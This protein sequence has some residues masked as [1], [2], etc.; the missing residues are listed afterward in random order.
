MN[1]H[2]IIQLRNN[3]WN[4]SGNN[5]IKSIFNILLSTINTFHHLKNNLFSIVY[6]KF[7]SNP[8]YYNFS[9]SV[10]SKYRTHLQKVYLF[11]NQNNNSKYFKDHILILFD[12]YYLLVNIIQ[13]NLY[14]VLLNIM[15][16]FYMEIH[17]L[18][19]TFQIIIGNLLN[20]IYNMQ[21]MCKNRN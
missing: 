19:D 9:N 17:K 8:K 15:S 4:I 10:P 14:T 18:L 3:P 13:N 1:I 20:M 16:R 11:K 6:I 2:L 12:K 7:D 21:L 5:H